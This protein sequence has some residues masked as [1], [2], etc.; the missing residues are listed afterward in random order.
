MS[1]KISFSA[2]R[3]C[4]FVA[5]AS[6]TIACTPV[7]TASQI[8]PVADDVLFLVLGKMSLYDQNSEGDISLRNHHFV[9]EIMPKEGGKIVSGSLTSATDPNQVI[10]FQP[11][12]NAFLAHGAR[13]MQP[14]ELHQLHPDGEYV[15]S[16]TTESGE[17]PSQPLLL[18]KR[19]TT[20]DMPAAAKITTSQNGIKVGGPVI[21]ASVDLTLGWKSM[22]GNTRAAT[23]ELDDLIFVL[24]FDCFAVESFYPEGFTF[25]VKQ[26]GLTQ[27][28][29]QWHA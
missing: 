13:V 11:E 4:T 5:L 29:R 2:S 16:Y 25:S 26:N 22:P 8:S 1:E 23:S 12:G 15:F 17:M 20:E 24:G 3:F 19:A 6:L 21:D 14:G 27:V 28:N 10:E 7:L 9:A 18:E